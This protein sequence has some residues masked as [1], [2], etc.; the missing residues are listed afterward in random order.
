MLKS[1]LKSA[2][3]DAVKYF[4]VRFVPA[5]T[6]LVTVP[7]F[8]RAVGAAEYG[9]FYL[10]TTA[11][12][13]A[14]AV[15]TAWITGAVVRFYWTY[16]K[17]ERLDDFVSTTLW[18][19]A[20]SIFGVSAII[21]MGAWLLRDVIPAGVLALVPVGLGSLAVNYFV[22]VALQ[23]L[24]AANRSTSYAVLSV[25]STLITTAFSIYF[26][27]SGDLGA[28]GILLGV[29]VGNLIVLPFSLRSIAREGSLAP[30]HVRRDVLAEFMRFGLP[31]V[32]ATVSSLLLVLSDRY[33][34]GIL[35]D[36]AEVGLYSL[37][38]GLG[39]KIMQLIT[40]PLIITMVPVMT[41]AF[42]QQG[43]EMA[44]KV[45]TQFTRYF[46]LATIPILGGLLA[47]GED[48]MTVF[49]GTEYHSAYPILPVV[50]GIAMCWA[51]V[52]LAGNGIALA[53]RSTIIM[54]NTLAGTAF[55]V[56]GNALFIPR[57]GYTAAAWTTL[58]AYGVIL[59]LTWLRSRTYLAWRIPAPD[60]LKALVAGA[61]LWTALRLVFAHAQPSI[62]LLLA[63]AAL[64]LATYAIVLL[65]LRAFHPDEIALVKSVTSRVLRRSRGHRM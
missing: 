53:K 51:L 29:V 41:Q 45:Q 27:A 31:L 46:A 56:A 1:I 43:A 25:A 60:V 44:Q 10:I 26:V 37:T 47:A 42:E 28:F 59:L 19:T 34:L 39:E 21:G 6:A 64:G 55:N 8:T 14:A 22:Q 12:S 35:R 57:Y 20:G 17:Q 63:E 49:T 2:G 15:A 7:I 18:A 40:L 13:V 33:M 48:F 30:T 38:Y 50:A 65:V 11:T 16:H 9:D 58:G 23:V 54:S 36:S 3:A 62:A 5:L 52:Q 61:A 24:R 32:P 4:P